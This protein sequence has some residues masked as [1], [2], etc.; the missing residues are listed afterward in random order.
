L[1]AANPSWGK[2]KLS[3]TG[4]L[5][6]LVENYTAQR[7]ERTLGEDLVGAQAKTLSEL[8]D[9]IRAVDKELTELLAML[10]TKSTVHERLHQA[11]L[12]LDIELSR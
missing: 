1:A 8:V 5:L 9:A 6:D 10:G 7:A 12:Q 2:R 11:I 3:A 4:T